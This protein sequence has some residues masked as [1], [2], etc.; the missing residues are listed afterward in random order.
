M[1]VFSK[2]SAQEPA[3][4]STA[5]TSALKCNVEGHTGGVNKIYESCGD[6]CEI[7]QST[8]REQSTDLEKRPARKS[9][10]VGAEQLVFFLPHPCVR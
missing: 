1:C 9:L 2:F 6:R 8:A 4:M 5:C 10:Q 7:Q 3:R